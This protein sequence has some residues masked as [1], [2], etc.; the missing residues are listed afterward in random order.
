[1]SILA[2]Y[3]FEQ[4]SRIAKSIQNCKVWLNLNFQQYNYVYMLLLLLLEF[5]KS[6]HAISHT[7]FGIL[8]S[9]ISKV[10]LKQVFELIL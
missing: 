4:C 9:V 5:Q 2:N 6:A 8:K 7:Y 10:A 1:M 3:A